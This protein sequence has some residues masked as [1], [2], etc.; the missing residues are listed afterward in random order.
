MGCVR[1][2]PKVLE[3]FLKYARKSQVLTA[4]RVVNMYL[5]GNRNGP[6]EMVAI[7]KLLIREKVINVKCE[8][9]FMRSM[10]EACCVGIKW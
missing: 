4:S 6:Y 1:R 10:M 9:C 8:D 2:D 5:R 3:L 7:L